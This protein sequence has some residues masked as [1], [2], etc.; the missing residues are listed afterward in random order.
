MEVGEDASEET[1]EDRVFL[2]NRDE[3]SGIVKS[4]QNGKLQFALPQTTLEIP[5]DR[6][7][8]LVLGGPKEAKAEVEPNE[9][10]GP[11]QVRSYFHGGGRLAFQLD[12][13]NQTKVSGRSPYF[14]K[15]S[16]PPG[17]IRR[18]RFNLER[19]AESIHEWE[20]IGGIDW[21]LNESN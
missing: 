10:A 15:V 12:Q 5:L 4:V 7:T 9:S 17:S 21:D 2:A 6:V 16:F 1:D 13:W 20:L 3:V 18:V 14:G 19:P 11:W 8:R